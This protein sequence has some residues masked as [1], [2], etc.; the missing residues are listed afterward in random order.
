MELTKQQP[1]LHWTKAAEMTILL[2]IYFTIYYLVSEIL[3]SI[4]VEKFFNILFS[5]I[6]TLASAYASNPSGFNKIFKEWRRKRNS[7]SNS[8]KKKG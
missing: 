8:K 4:D 1:I 3:K 2:V 6:A 7:N 5:G